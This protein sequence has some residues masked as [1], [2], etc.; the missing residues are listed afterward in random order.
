MEKTS[1]S[2][3][4]SLALKGVAIIMMMFHHCFR[5]ESFFENFEVSFFP[6]SQNLIV[7]ISSVFKI[8]VSIFVFITGYGL[9]LSL[10]KSFK[11][12]E[13]NNLQLSKWITQRL[14][15]MLSGF[16][17]VALLAYIICEILNGKTSRVFFDD[18]ISLGIVKIFLN[19][20]GLSEFFGT[21]NFDSSW[22]YMSV[23]ILYVVTLPCFLKLFKKYS[24]VFV[25]IL[26]VAFPRIIGWDYVNSSYISFLFALL[27]GA[28]FAENDLM[29]K[30]VNLKI[31][32]N[33]YSNKIAKFLIETF[34]LI[35]V[36][37]LS[38]ILP[39]SKF[40]E[41]RYAIIPSFVMLYLYEFFIDL[42]VLK[43][44]LC[45]LGKHSMNIFLVHQFVRTDY[46]NEFVYSFKHFVLI[47]IVLLSIS[48]L[49]SIAIE[50]LK[51]IIKFDFYIDKVQKKLCCLIDEFN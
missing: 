22:W 41:I 45:F 33:K 40:W 35:I 37:K 11:D 15:K 16:W 13:W 47:G 10:K 4:N 43:N 26:V 28:V 1:F 32:K 8:C 12:Y 3:N 14:I 39:K 34:L 50:L 5:T 2:N 23:A 42:P 7:D 9:T 29:V 18:G 51:K 30:I 27:L 48:L 24:Y 21:P 31:F 36:V 19:F 44:V 49:I 6:F 46:L 38:L 20:I 25:L 17:F